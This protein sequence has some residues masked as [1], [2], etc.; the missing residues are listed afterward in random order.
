[1]LSLYKQRERI[2]WKSTLKAVLLDTDGIP[3]INM[4]FLTSFITV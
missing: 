1:M 3:R 4:V 2:H